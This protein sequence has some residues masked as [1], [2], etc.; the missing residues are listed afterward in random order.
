[1]GEGARGMKTYYERM[2]P[3]CD[4]L[5]RIPITG[6][7]SKS[8]KNDSRPQGGYPWERKRP[9]EKVRSLWIKVFK[10]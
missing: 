8:V 9:F 4:S 6:A 2:F 1:M 3:N 5:H 10:W 7:F